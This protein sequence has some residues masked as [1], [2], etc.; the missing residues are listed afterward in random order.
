MTVCVAA[1]FNWTYG[2]G[3]TGAAIVTASD[4]QITAGDIE[5][6][7]PQIKVCFLTPRLMILIAGSYAIHSEALRYTQRTLLE[8]PEI[9]PGVIAEI[10]A[11]YIRD[12]KGRFARQTYLAPLGLSHEEFLSK[13][14]D[15]S[16]DFLLRLTSQL[17][18]Y[19]TEDTEALVVGADDRTTHLFVVDQNCHVT[20]HNDVGFAAIGVGAWHAKSQ[21]M[22]AGYS[23]Q[24]TYAVALGAVYLAK[25]VAEVAPGVRTAVEKS[26]TVA[27]G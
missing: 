4:R 26:A 17:Q 2:P 7:P 9:D 27:A 21:I 18:N 23:N 15:F 3:D 8:T 13:Q 22:R 24:F 11:S 6:E 5:Y 16:A 19:Q 20:Y 25:K 12:I 14:K 1:V 10:Y